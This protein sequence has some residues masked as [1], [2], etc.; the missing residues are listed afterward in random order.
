MTETMDRN[1]EKQKAEE[2]ESLC[3]ISG[4]SRR[5]DFNAGPAKKESWGRGGRSRSKRR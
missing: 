5:S 2:K 1:M 3:L 4:S